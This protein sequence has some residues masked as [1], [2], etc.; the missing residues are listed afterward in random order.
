MDEIEKGQ[1]NPGFCINPITLLG[2]PAMA[3]VPWP[4]ILIF[5]SF[6]FKWPIVLPALIYSASYRF[7]HRRGYTLSGII[8]RLSVRGNDGAVSNQPPYSSDWR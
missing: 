8:T 7:L 5:W 6:L 2:M 1:G 3:F 4:V